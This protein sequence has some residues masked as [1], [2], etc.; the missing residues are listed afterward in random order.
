[1]PNEKK[2]TRV[3]WE[4]LEHV[5]KIGRDVSARRVHESAFPNGEKAFTTV[6]TVLTTLV[7][8]KVLKCRKIGMVNF[9][10]PVKSRA[11]MLMDQLSLVASQMFHGSVPDMTNFL[12]DAEHLNLKDINKLKAILE[13]KERRLKDNSK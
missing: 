13:A 7:K 9:Y 5:W 10:I 2:L 4:I 8:K 6:Q 12:I 1:M 11:A 3:E